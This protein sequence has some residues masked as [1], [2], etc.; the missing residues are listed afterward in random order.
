MRTRPRTDVDPPRVE[1]PYAGACRLV[2]LGV[3]SCFV[4]CGMV[5]YGR[6]LCR[7]QG[8]RGDTGPPGPPGPPGYLT[9]NGNYT[10]TVSNTSSTA[11]A[12]LL[13]SLSVTLT[14]PQ[15]SRPQPQPHVDAALPVPDNSTVLGVYLKRTCSRV[16]SVSSALAVLNDY[17][18]YISTHSLTYPQRTTD[19]STFTKLSSTRNLSNN[20]EQSLKCYSVMGSHSSS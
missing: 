9:A 10:T 12:C 18:L 16:T 17:T 13:W 20:G 6:G 15:V 14:R 2:A 7:W 11:N 19:E 1:S 3:V 5:W 4:G 8:P